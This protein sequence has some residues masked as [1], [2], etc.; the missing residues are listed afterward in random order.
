MEPNTIIFGDLST[1]TPKQT[2]KFYETVFGWKYYKDYNYY[3]A[4][5]GYDMVTGLYETPEKFKEM[6]MPHFWM[7]YIQVENVD[8]VV[9]KAKNLGGIVEMEQEVP[10]LGK[11]ALIRDPQGAG[12]TVYEGDALES[13]RTEDK[14]C[15]LIWN[16]LHISN[17]QNIIPFYGGIFNWSFQSA[18]EGTFK[19]YTQ[20]NTHIA[21]ALEISNVYKGK[22]EYWVCTFGVNDLNKSK[23]KIVDNGGAIIVD[24]GIRV[25]C[26]DHSN[27][28][29]FY[30]Q[31]VS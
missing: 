17:T 9:H 29:F 1:Y 31:E 28:S 22:Y 7:T 14:A 4:Y 26:T 16:E 2:I 12:F 5:K 25:L 10:G 23:R 11:V 3:L 15:T 19:I 18:G 27:Q 8:N 6:K 21:D 20:N 24:E 13:T 30:I